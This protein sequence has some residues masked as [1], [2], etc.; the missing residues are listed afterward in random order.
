MFHSFESWRC[1]SQSWKGLVDTRMLSLAYQVSHF[2]VTTS[3]WLDIDASID[4]G[5]LTTNIWIRLI[6]ALMFVLDGQEV[7]HPLHL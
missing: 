3:T 6:V 2:D 5:L 4:Y 1:V 7:I